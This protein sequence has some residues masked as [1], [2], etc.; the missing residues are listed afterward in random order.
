MIPGVPMRTQRV[1]LLLAMMFVSGLA[2]ADSFYCG[3]HIIEEGLSMDDV[4]AKCGEPESIEGNTWRY[5]RG[6]NQFDVVLHFGADSTINRIVEV[7][8]QGAVDAP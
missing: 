8:D 4:Q 6:S 1:F 5:A 3:T 7:S 2:S